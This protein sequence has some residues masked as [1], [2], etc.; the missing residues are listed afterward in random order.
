MNP[1]MPANKA[2]NQ[3]WP[4]P[5]IEHNYRSQHNDSHNTPSQVG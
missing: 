4:T 5:E 2:V 3:R 1:T